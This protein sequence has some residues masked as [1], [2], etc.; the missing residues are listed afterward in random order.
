MKNNYNPTQDLHNYLITIFTT[1]YYELIKTATCISKSKYNILRYISIANN[2]YAKYNL[3]L[4]I[5]IS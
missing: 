4:S 5:N 1:I 3:F 2:K